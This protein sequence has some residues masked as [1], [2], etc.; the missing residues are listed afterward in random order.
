MKTIT[1]LFIFLSFV[2]T[3]EAANQEWIE[4]KAK[5]FIIYYK[6]ASKDFVETVEDSAEEYYE[7]IR[8]NL[9]FRR[10][11][12]WTWDDRARIYI[13]DDQEDYVNSS[14]AAGWSSGHAYTREKIIRTYPSA[15]GFF[16][17][18]LP[19]ELGH[20]IFR[21]FIGYKSRGI[22]LWFIEGVAMYQEKAK[23]YGSD[24]IVKESIEDGTFMP[25]EELSNMR[26]YHHT[27]QEKVDLFYA[28][29]ASVVNY[30]ISE[31][32]EYR[33]VNFCR[34]LQEGVDFLKALDTIYGRFN[35]IE[36][37]NRAW[38]GHIER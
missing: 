32:G 3:L 33:F 8:Q 21:E 9:G 24:H 17:T 6:N 25:L 20:I 37:L 7:E 31:Q 22:P 1:A 23:R 34:K 18:T 4:Y 13:Y 36:G 38:K 10:Y 15:T 29:S 5:H 12:G 35:G 19:H 16:D 28:E 27:T 26:L 2:T 30:L 14:K 11:S